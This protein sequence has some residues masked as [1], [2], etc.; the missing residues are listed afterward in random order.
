[1]EINKINSTINT[2]MGTNKSNRGAVQPLKVSAEV[3]AATA[4]VSDDCKLIAHGKSRLEQL[5]DV[6][7]AKVAEV[8]QSLIDG[9]FDLNIDKLTD[10][11]VLQH[12]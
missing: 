7:M 5:P 6:D 10:A 12:G 1:M 9:S 8:R 4:V 11:M 3:A 2:E